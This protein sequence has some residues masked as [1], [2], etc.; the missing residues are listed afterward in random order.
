M[1]FPTNAP[2]PPVPNID[3]NFLQFFG[4]SWAAIAAQAQTRL[5]L[6]VG[7]NNHVRALPAAGGA[8]AE[9]PQATRADIHHPAQAFDRERRTVFFDKPKPH[10]VGHSLGPMAFMPSITRKELGGFF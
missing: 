4:H 5:F 10:G 7:Q 1:V 2:D 6:D 9:G 3:P 8:A